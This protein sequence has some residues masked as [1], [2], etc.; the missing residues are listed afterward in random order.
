MKVLIVDDED[1][2]TRAL[3][4]CLR[5]CGY[6]THTARDGVEALRRI[7]AERP[8]VVI[9][10]MNMPNMNGLEL[11]KAIGERFE[12]MAVILVTGQVRDDKTRAALAESG[13]ACLD[14]PFCIEKMIE[15]L[16]QIEANRHGAGPLSSFRPPSKT[17]AR[18]VVMIFSTHHYN[19]TDP[20]EPQVEGRTIIVENIA[21]ECRCRIAFSNERRGVNATKICSPTMQRNL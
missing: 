10:D 20:M 9:T 12:E 2:C 11:L 3:S 4:R 13:Y 16:A 21:G 18:G 5:L 1:V 8:D 6:E 15:M 19:P 7:E 17:H 14:K